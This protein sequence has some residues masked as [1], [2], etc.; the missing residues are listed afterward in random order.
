MN[1]L[2]APSCLNSVGED[3]YNMDSAPHMA[4]SDPSPLHPHSMAY[5]MAL[6]K[7]AEVTEGTSFA[8]TTSYI[9]ADSAVADSSSDF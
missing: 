3:T 4:E 9:F 8:D 6:D 2:P 7:A 1:S 5:Q